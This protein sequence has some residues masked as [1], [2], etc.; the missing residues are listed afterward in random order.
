MQNYAPKLNK[1]CG[2]IRPISLPVD[3]VVPNITHVTM[4]IKTD[5]VCM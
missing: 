2:K 1:H 3:L 5:G 4:N